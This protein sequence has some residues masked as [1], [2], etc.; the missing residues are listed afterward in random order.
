MVLRDRELVAL[1]NDVGAKT[2]A[3][4]GQSPDESEERQVGAGLRACSG[5]GEVFV[6]TSFER[7]ADHTS[8]VYR[9]GGRKL[10][11]ERL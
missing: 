11:G 7:S 9:S 8:S 5:A 4:D 2:E 6:S 10:F 3:D 1:G